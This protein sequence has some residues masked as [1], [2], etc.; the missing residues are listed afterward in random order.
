MLISVYS[1]GFSGVSRL[2]RSRVLSKELEE[3]INALVRYGIRFS[4]KRGHIFIRWEDH[5]KYIKLCEERLLPK[6]VC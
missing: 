4:V 2:A 5:D 6:T 3:G 1:L